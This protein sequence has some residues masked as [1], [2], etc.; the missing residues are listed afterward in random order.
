MS[1]EHLHFTQS[2]EPLQG[3]GLGYAALGL[4][5]SLFARGIPSRLVTT[6]AEGFSVDVP[7]V[8]LFPRRGPERA[9]YSP[10]M[11][12]QASELIQVADVI[13]GHGFYVGPNACLGRQA[14]RLD[15]PLIY[16]VHGFF[17]P[18]ILKRSRWKKRLA[19][20]LFENANFDHANLWRALSQ[21]EEQQIRSVG[22]Q[23]PIVVLPNGVN[24]PAERSEEERIQIDTMFPRARPKR[25]LFLSRI[26]SKKGL[27]LLIQSWA[28][29]P[30]PLTND[31]ELALFGPDEGGYAADVQR[32]IDQAELSDSVRLMGSV[33]GEAKE[34]A[35]RSSDLFVLP[36]YSEGFP[37]A[38]LEAASFGLPVVLTDECNFPELAATGGG[39]ECKPTAES[40]GDSLRLALECGDR[41]RTERGQA[42][43]DLVAQHYTWGSIATRLDDACQALL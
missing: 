38:V 34:A 28:S 43:Q 31:W 18:W 13:H 16:H 9:F 10:M 4:H 24:L 37:M 23:S 29:L 5:L 42:G 3:A 39:W 25:L 12:R 8:T 1:T 11:F 17:D 30:K 20:W 15:K 7:N 33:S 27:D 6:C 32:W 41:E 2:T 36:S 22:I 14:R 40:V 35:F 19:H 26:H 21:K